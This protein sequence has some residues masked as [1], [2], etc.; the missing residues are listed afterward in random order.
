[1]NVPFVRSFDIE[2]AWRRE[3]FEDKDQFTHRTH[4]YTNENEDEN[5]AG[6]PRISLRYQPIPDLTLRA[7]AG[8]SFRS[9]SLNAQFSPVAQNFPQIFD[10]FKRQT[11]QPPEGVWQGGNTELKPER[12]DAY[13]AGLVYTPKWLPG[14]TMTVDWY[15]L[16]TRDLIVGA[17]D[18][19]QL[20]LTANGTDLLNGVNPPRFVDPDGCGGGSGALS[21]PGGPGLGITRDPSTGS[22]SCIDS[23]NSNAG[24][25]LVQG[26]DVTAVYEIPTERWGKFTFSGGY[27]HFFTWKAEPIVGLGTHSF[28][29]NYNN[30]TIPLAPGALP[31]NKGFLRLEWEWHH[32]DFIATGNYIGDFRDDSAFLGPDY[33]RLYG[34]VPRNVPS[35]TSLDLQLSYEWV[36][37]PTEP[38]PYVKESKDSKNAAPVTEAATASFFQ[39]MLWGTKLTVGVN[40][41]F[42]RYPPSVLGAF[43]DNYDTSLYSIRNRYWYVSLTKKF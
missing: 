28:L 36:K 32:F 2:I 6:S 9:A 37:P 4:S 20:M 24:K 31:W 10:P 42:D 3:W 34:D 43:N 26:I 25:R 22:L 12:T 41:V 23:I 16:F 11:L 21:D 38:A 39:R 27:N 15:Q 19:A 33:F 8:Q 7:T 1:M 30:G 5:F 18:F 40:D 35:Y 17:A 14:F 29:G 13:S